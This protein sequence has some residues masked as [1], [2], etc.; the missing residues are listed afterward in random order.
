ML[1]FNDTVRIIAALIL[2]K[3][4]Q[5]RRSQLID[6]FNDTSYVGQFGGL[7]GHMFEILA[8]P[9]IATGGPFQCRQLIQKPVGRP[10]KASYN[11]KENYVFE[12]SFS[13]SQAA[14]VNEMKKSIEM[15]NQ[16]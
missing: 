8:N 14:Y 5:D 3:Y 12:I 6:F 1:Q 16:L 15:K 7:R 4:Q 10:P 11:S 13:S 2:L 9:V